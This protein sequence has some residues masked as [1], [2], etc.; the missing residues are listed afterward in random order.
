MTPKQVDLI[1]KSFDAMWPI[2]G[3]FADLCYS[4]F[5]ELAPNTRA[6]FPSDMK[7]QRLKLMDMIAAL[8]GSL[9]QREP[10]ESLAAY[11]GRQRE[12]TRTGPQAPAEPFPAAR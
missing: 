1:R 5:F 7:R 6:L 4:R 8:V 9:D 2:R 10:F 11:S 3:D 12:F